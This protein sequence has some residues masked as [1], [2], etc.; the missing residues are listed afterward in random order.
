MKNPCHNCEERELGCHGRC[1]R[2]IEWANERRVLREKAT[3]ERILNLHL[4]EEP[5]RAI[6]RSKYVNNRRKK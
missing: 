2:Y 1:E 4:D 6:K 3:A 5:F